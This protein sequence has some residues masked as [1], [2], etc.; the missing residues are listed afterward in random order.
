VI[1]LGLR[2]TDIEDLER[3]S[4]YVS[5]ASKTAATLRRH[6]ATEEEIEILVNEG[7]RVELNAL[8]SDELVALI[9]R[10]LAKNGIA[11]VVPDD[12]TLADAYRRM[13]R[14]A[15]VQ[16]KI[17]ELVE[18]LDEDEIEIPDDLHDRVDALL[19]ENPEKSWDDVVAEIA[20]EAVDADGTNGSA[21]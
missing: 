14:Q 7:E 10:K 13:H 9:E 2:V 19:R 3:E 16:A 18:Q 20:Y 5:S 4:V 21:P 8:T 1:D 15:L 11:K 6:G 12:K 17:D